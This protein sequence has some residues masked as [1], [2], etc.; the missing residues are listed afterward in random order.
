MA[1]SFKTR[2]SSVGT[3]AKRRKKGKETQEQKKTRRQ[4]EK[5]SIEQCTKLLPYAGIF[6]LFLT[7]LFWKFYV[8]LGLGIY[9]RNFYGEG[10]YVNSVPPSIPSGTI[11][12]ADY[13]LE[14]LRDM[15]KKSG[16][17]RFLERVEK[18][19]VRSGREGGLGEEGLGNTE[20]EEE[21]ETEEL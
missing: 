17:D 1:K 7:L 8:N 21:G 4:A 5:Q 2:G 16:D 19:A 14:E 11:N 10:Y 20:G 9:T 18:Y 15:A 6:L 3:H 12:F 13:S